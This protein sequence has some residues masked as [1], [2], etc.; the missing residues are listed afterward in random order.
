MERDQDTYRLTQSRFWR[1][2]EDTESSQRWNIP[3]T[4]ATKAEDFENTTSNYGVFKR[5]QNEYVVELPED[6]GDF[7]VVNV[8]QFG[9]YRVN[10]DLESWQ[11]ISR[12]LKSPNFGGIHEANRAQVIY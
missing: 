7:F 10:Y 6:A 9:Y 8:Q 4:Y 2:G 1:D 11:A 5:T 3:I 12:A